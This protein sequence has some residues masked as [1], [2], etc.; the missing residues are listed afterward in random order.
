MTDILIT[1]GRGFI[2]KNL[3]KKLDHLGLSYIS[4]DSKNGDINNQKTFSS[5]PKVKTVIHLA[6][7]SFVPSSWQDNN[8]F[9]LTNII[10]TQNVL[11][12]C[13]N[14]GA[15]LIMAS[16]YVYG[17]PEELPIKESHP[18]RPNNP[19]ALSKF[20]AEQ[21]VEFE[22]IH[23][24]LDSVILRIFNIYGCGQKD[25]FL[26]S[27]ILEQIK[28]NKNIN[29]FDLKPKR[30]FVFIDD[31]VDAF[32]C[33]MSL[34][35]G[36]YKFNIGSGKSYSVQEII[37][38]IQDLLGTNLEIFS[39]GKSRKNEINDVKADISLAKKVLK[40]E[41]KYDI[42]NGLN[43]FIHESYDQLIVQ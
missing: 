31:V 7:K 8:N 26:I 16:S 20:M 29:I 17:I 41:P 14:V 39:Q 19:Y 37:F 30:D 4:I 22:Y 38:L 34:N 9:F 25:Y 13:K 6:G 42:K 12:Y 43:K 33:A 18:V 24:K 10:G 36:F 32:I 11:N 28:N 40:W 23:S 5:L 27:K 15:K 21:L 35:H 2:G 1:G 3:T